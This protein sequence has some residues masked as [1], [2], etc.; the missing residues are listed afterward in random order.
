MQGAVPAKNSLV[1]C[2]INS[3]HPCSTGT[4]AGCL[5]ACL[6][7]ILANDAA[8][9]PIKLSSLPCPL[10]VSHVCVCPFPAVT[11]TCRLS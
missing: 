11:N 9:P 7:H 3:Q 1:Q 5:F 4:A 10:L 2:P 8:P 6:L